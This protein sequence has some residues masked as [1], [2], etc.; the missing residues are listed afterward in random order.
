VQFF[1]FR[2]Q[3]V[4]FFVIAPQGQEE[5]VRNEEVAEDG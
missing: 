1:T 5:E 4:P 2:L 3:G